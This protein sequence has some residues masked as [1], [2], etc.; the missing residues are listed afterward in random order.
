MSDASGSDSFSSGKGDEGMIPSIGTN[1]DTTDYRDQAQDYLPV[2]VEGLRSGASLDIEL[3]TRIGNDFF[4]IKQK[5]LEVDARLMNR[6][7]AS[8]IPYV[9][10]R[11]QDRDAYQGR[12]EKGLSKV[13]DSPA[14]S[15]REK[16]GVLTDYAVEIVDQLFTDPGNPGTISSA[17][18]LTQECVRF[19]GSSKHAF[20]HLVELSSHDQY[21]YAHSVGVAAYAVALAPEVTNLTPQ[22]LVD[23]GLAGLL[24]DIG[25][26]MVDPA[27]INKK[28]PLSEDEWA[29]MKKHPEYGADIIKRHKNLAAIIGVAAESHHENQMGT[30]YPKGVIATQLDPIVRMV[31]LADAFSAMT[32][33]RSY[34]PPRDSVT[35]LKLIKEGLD[36]K[37]DSA[38]F[39]PFVRLFLDP[40]KKIA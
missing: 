1:Q 9:F 2:T 7:R 24:H 14:L 27:I 5:G 4:V 32:T 30:G 35:A 13:I 21:T 22:Q 18:N 38:L 17:K 19:I 12:L 20:L 8:K 26:C 10:I 40:E 23:I 31:S 36:K 3:F 34:S 15:I 11:T 33:K 39:Q 29:Q 16:A 25:K 37:F 6:L 28:G